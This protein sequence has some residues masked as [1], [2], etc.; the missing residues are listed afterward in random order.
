MQMM[1]C[2]SVYLTRQRSPDLDIFVDNWNFA[3]AL[4]DD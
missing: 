1:L 4:I 2:F 3:S